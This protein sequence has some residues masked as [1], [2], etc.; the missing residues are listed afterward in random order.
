MRCPCINCE[1]RSATCHGKCEEYKEWAAERAKL[2]RKESA[3]RAKSFA[4]ERQMRS[5]RP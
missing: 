5:W 2:N 4:V 3:E 1:N